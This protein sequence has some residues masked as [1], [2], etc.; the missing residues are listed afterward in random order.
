[1]GEPTGNL[2]D[3]PRGLLMDGRIRAD[4]SLRLPLWGARVNSEPA[5]NRAD[6]V[7]TDFDLEGPLESVITKGV[8][9]NGRDAAENDIR[10]KVTNGDSDLLGE[11]SLT[12]VRAA[13]PDS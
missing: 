11:R 3:A 8:S 1:M 9:T 13:S 2:P 5:L 4:P 7:E 6:P 12:L 10:S